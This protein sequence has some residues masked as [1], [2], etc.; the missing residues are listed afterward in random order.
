MRWFGLLLAVAGQPVEVDL[1]GS[2]HSASGPRLAFDV[3]GVLRALTLAD[4][5]RVLTEAA[6]FLDAL[7][8]GARVKC[9]WPTAAC[10]SNGGDA[11]AVILGAAAA[12]AWPAV[13]SVGN[14]TD[15]RRPLQH[16]TLQVHGTRL[17]V[18]SASDRPEVARASW[19]SWAAY[20]RTHGYGFLPLDASGTG[21]VAEGA[22]LVGQ[23]SPLRSA[24]HLKLWL[25]HDLLESGASAY[26]TIVWVDDDVVATS[27]ATPH[28]AL[29]LAED[30]LAVDA[31][32]T[33]VALEPFNTGVVVA[34]RGGDRASSLLRRAWLA[35]FATERYSCLLRD[36]GWWDNTALGLAVDADAAGFVLLPY[37][38]LQAFWSPL[39]FCGTEWTHCEWVQSLALAWA[40]GDF[41]AHAG[42]GSPR[43]RAARMTRL[44]RDRRGE[45]RVEPR[46]LLGGTPAAF[47]QYREALVLALRAANVSAAAAGAAAAPT[48]E[49]EAAVVDALGPDAS[50]AVAERLPLVTGF[51]CRVD[52]AVDGTEWASVVFGLD[53]DDFDRKLAREL[54][55]AGIRAPLGRPDGGPACATLACVAAALR[56]AAEANRNCVP[57]FRVEHRDLDLVP[58]PPAPRSAVYDPPAPPARFASSEWAARRSRG[59]AD[60]FEAFA[61]ETFTGKF[62]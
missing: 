22:A 1:D 28:P 51:S 33:F 17:L 58:P 26:Q 47:G 49:L 34:T 54:E 38:S 45:R 61:R 27:M 53:A 40:P 60:R 18:V 46:R 5:A 59:F 41:A 29:A 23:L 35:P 11:A 8:A 36:C 20:A 52:L 50:H 3:D 24:H 2:T 56:A 13:A 39:T 48:A 6:A 9:A 31:L 10:E 16:G 42:G 25:L 32:P 57:G 62:S 44:L 7:P 43:D 21:L 37:G 30:T 4:P 14:L 15:G 55:A 19:T 12:A